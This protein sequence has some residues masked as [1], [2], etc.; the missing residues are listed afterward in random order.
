VVYRGEV[1]ANTADIEDMDLREGSRAYLVLSSNVGWPRGPCKPLRV[2][3]FEGLD[4]HFVMDVLGKLLEDHS[5][6][7]EHT[8]E[9]LRAAA[10]LM[11]IPE[12][13]WDGECVRGCVRAW[14][15]A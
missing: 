1:W 15:H 9:G 7:F 10:Q 11:R 6:P 12:E 5:S 13:E 3:S 8:L 2:E 14:V 4:V